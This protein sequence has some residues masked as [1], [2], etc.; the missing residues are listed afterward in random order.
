ME[1]RSIY[2]CVALLA[3]AAHRAAA[4]DPRSIQVRIHDLTPST[5][6]LPSTAQN[7]VEFTDNSMLDV[8]SYDA[9]YTAI[10]AAAGEC[11]EPCECAACQAKRNALKKAVA[12]AYAPLFYNNKFDYLCDPA[13]GDH[14]LGENLKRL[15][16]A[17]SMVLDIGGQYRARYHGERN[18]RGLGLTGRDDDFLLH[19]TRLYANLEIG[20]RVRLYGEMIDADSNGENFAPRGIEVNRADMQNLFADVA[21]FDL[22]DG[23]VTARIGRQELLYGSQRLVSPLDWG[24]TRRTFEGLDF[25]YR[26]ADWTVNAFLT[27]PVVT[28]PRNFDSA[29][30]RQAFA[31]VFGSHKLRENQTLDLYYIYFSNENVPALAGSN[32]I[33]DNTVGSRWQGSHECLLWD[34]EGAY[35][36]GTND[37]GSDH[38]AGFAVAGL[39]RKI[40]HPW[41]P[42]VWAY[43][44]WSS[45]GNLTG[46]RRGF[47][48][49]FPLV[50]KYHGFMDLYSRSNIET[51]NMTLEFQPHEKWKVLA[52]YHYFFLENKNDSPYNVNMSAFNGGTAPRSADLGHEIDLIATWQLKPRMDLVFGYSHFFAG[53]YYRLTPNVPFQGDADFFY[54][55]FTLNF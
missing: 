45:G 50:H 12:S 6:S 51:P 37:D 4:E 8:E 1:R 35:Q 18:L 42:V 40:D 28:D 3:L 24:N 26:S 43:Y 11:A 33:H 39:G 49:L 47:D 16:V 25:I 13:Y 14:H 21:L 41:K 27:R 29:D 34:F 53:D 15:C 38:N 52:W 55:Q 9:S 31:G 7:G 19:R 10:S 5:E 2:V 48:H 36:F 44:D 32:G 17:E 30:Y 20:S 23:D 22:L 54:T 46:Q